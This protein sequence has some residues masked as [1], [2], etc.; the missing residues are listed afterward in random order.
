MVRNKVKFNYRIIK[1]SFLGFVEAPVMCISKF[2][3]RISNKLKILTWFTNELRISECSLTS[4][5][6]SSLA[7]V[8]GSYFVKQQKAIEKLWIDQLSK[9]G[10]MVTYKCCIAIS[11]IDYKS[12]KSYK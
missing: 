6:L 1:I 5:G 12:Y 9:F 11:V 7:A 4:V 10:I 2:V 8:C 3:M